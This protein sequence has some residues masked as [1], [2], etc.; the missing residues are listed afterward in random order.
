VING[1]MMSG[2]YDL[3]GMQENV[4]T[5]DGQMPHAIVINTRNVEASPVPVGNLQWPE[6]ITVDG[7]MVDAEPTV[8]T[9]DKTYWKVDKAALQEVRFTKSAAEA[10]GAK[11]LES[12]TK[13]EDGSY[14]IKDNLK[15]DLIVPSNTSETASLIDTWTFNMFSNQVMGLPD[16]K[17]VPP[18]K[19]SGFKFP[20]IGKRGAKRKDESPSEDEFSQ[21]K[22]K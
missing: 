8:A 12:F 9:K 7:N 15:E 21:Y 10:M 13:N 16:V 22:R 5:I 14:V 17:E 18:A 6:G 2:K 4:P 19:K 11:G 20:K 3:G 1:R